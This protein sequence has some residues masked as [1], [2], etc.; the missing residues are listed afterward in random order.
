MTES[1]AVSDFDLAATLGSGQVFHWHRSGE[2]FLG[3]VGA[4]PLTVSQ[5]A[6]G[7][8]EVG[9]GQADLARRYFALDHDL[10]KIRL[11]LPG[12]DEHLR[13]ALEFAPGLRILRQP[14]WECLATFITSSLK[15]VAHIRQIS[16]LLRRRFGRHVAT[17]GEVELHAYPTPRALAD[18]GEAALRACGLGYR[19]RF[20]Q[21]TA[22]RVADGAF[23]LEAVAELE[24]AA[25]LEKLCELPGVGPKIAQC[26]LL[27]AWE[28]L[29]LFP[30]DVWIE[31]ALR[32]LYFA[33]ARRP[34][35]SRKLRD[36]AWRHF[37]PYRGYAQQ[38]LFHH[39]RTSGTF[40]RKRKDG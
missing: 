23:D 27:F 26:S 40:S 33:K 17:V 35:A 21:Q 12:D 28:R 5:P 30:I 13:R 29:G 9:R 16:L 7:L 3:L 39:A 19:A 25:A 1:I 37:G 38:W 14:H 24:D 6:P 22:A 34:P 36:F 8:L 20:L 18:A 32:E 11:T 15:Q 10:E 31:R 2:G 4:E